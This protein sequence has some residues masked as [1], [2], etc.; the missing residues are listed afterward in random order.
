MNKRFF[1]SMFMLA[2]L[3]SLWSNFSTKDEANIGF[4]FNPLSNDLLLRK[5]PFHLEMSFLQVL[6]DVKVVITE[7]LIYA[8]I[9][10]IVAFTIERYLSFIAT[11]ISLTNASLNSLFC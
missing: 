3:A 5:S 1:F 9:L 7:T 6:C 2:K 10:T 4:P 11:T 8:S